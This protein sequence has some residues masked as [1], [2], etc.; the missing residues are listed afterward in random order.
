MGADHVLSASDPDWADR[1][2]G[3]TR[4]QGPEVL[5][6]MSGSP[7]AIAGG[8]GALRSGGTAALLGLPPEPVAIDLPNHVIFKGVTLLG[9]NGRLMFD[10]WYQAEELLSTGRV[11]VRDVV[12]HELPLDE[13]DNAFELIGR[14]EALKVLLRAS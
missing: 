14:G 11:D 12:S 3:L 13:L 4:S 6:E 7:T 1:A 5:L 8:L 9:I 10:T 2:R